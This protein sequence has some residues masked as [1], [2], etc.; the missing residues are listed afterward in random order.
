MTGSIT[1]SSISRQIAAKIICCKCGVSTDV[2]AA[3]LNATGRSKRGGCAAIWLYHI[4]YV[5][6]CFGCKWQGGTCRVAFG[7]RLRAAPCQTQLAPKP[8]Q[9]TAEHISQAGG[10]SVEAYS[11]KGRNCQ[12]EEVGRKW[13]I[14]SIGNIK[15]RGEGGGASWQSRYPLQCTED[16]MLEEA[17]I[18]KGTG[19]WR[20]HTGAEEKCKKEGVAERNHCVLS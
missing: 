5:K 11:R 7:T 14:N 18:P 6:L 1:N 15:V 4:I 10:I 12:E 16:P 2:N 17:D 3:C 9:D 13:L 20:A 8:L 19:L